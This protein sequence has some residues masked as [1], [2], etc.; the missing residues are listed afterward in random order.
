MKK[1]VEC[2]FAASLLFLLHPALVNSMQIS[3]R[4]LTP[5][6]EY[7][8]ITL[9]ELA[10]VYKRAYVAQKFHVSTNTEKTMTDGSQVVHLVLNMANHVYP[11]RKKAQISFLFYSPNH[12]GCKP[13]SVTRETFSVGDSNEYTGEEWDA[14]QRELIATDEMALNKVRQVLGK[15][16]PPLEERPTG[17][18]IP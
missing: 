10:S 7:R 16:T 3:T 15:S 1:S 14:F 4:V 18:S 6:T 11:T 13:C 12:D 2:M 17:Q 5:A 9:K 8:D